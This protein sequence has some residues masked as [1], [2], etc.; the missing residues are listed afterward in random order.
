MANELFGEASVKI[1]DKE[2][3]LR[4]DLNT[5]ID[6]QGV[7]GLKPDQLQA[8]LSKDPPLDLV[9]AVFWAC[10]QE[11]HPEVTQR[12]A[13]T[14]MSKAGDAIGDVMNRVFKAAMPDADPQPSPMQPAK[15]R[16]GAGNR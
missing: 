5:L 8:A 16:A 14:L 1:G 12:G 15:R 2:F 4:L 10:L 13:G 7:T 3:T 9:R 6:I 11:F